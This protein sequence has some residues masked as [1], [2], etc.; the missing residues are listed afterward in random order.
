MA[1]AENTQRPSSIEDMTASYSAETVFNSI[2]SGYAAGISGVLVGHPMDSAKVWL[3]TKGMT[4]A[5]G[6]TTA[7]VTTTAT[8]VANNVSSGLTSSRAPLNATV[9]NNMSTLAVPS[10][11]ERGFN[12]RSIRALY[13][14]VTGPLLTVGMIQSL[15]FAIYDSLRRILHRHSHP[16]A[17]DSDYL[18]N[19]SL[20]NV[21]VS[22]MAAGSVLA[23][24]TSP[25]LVV[26]T[27]QQIMEWNFQRAVRDTLQSNK[28]SL[29]KR[30]VCWI[31]STLYSGSMWTR[32]LFLHL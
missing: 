23:L 28:K 10:S 24:C 1:L 11:Q 27:K 14:G 29:R 30:V 15:N 4:P 3:Q 31:R 12:L 19:D 8:N 9:G 16:L 7:S 2:A 21:T 5:T 22:A 26:K 13:S 17:S 20:A 18:H 25:L 6:S 32:Y